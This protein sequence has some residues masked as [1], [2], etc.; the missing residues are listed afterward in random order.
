LTH[1]WKIHAWI[2]NFTCL[3]K[4]QYIK[5]FTYFLQNFGIFWNF[6]KFHCTFLVK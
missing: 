6:S 1:F 5:I 3:Q 4:F 2:T